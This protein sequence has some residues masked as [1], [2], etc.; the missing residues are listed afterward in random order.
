VIYERRRAVQGV[1]SDPSPWLGEGSE[2][3]RRCATLVGHPAVRVNMGPSSFERRLKP[4][5][6]CEPTY[7][8]SRERKNVLNL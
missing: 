4:K 3:H 6:M 2:A 7:Q 5:I 8:S 1:K